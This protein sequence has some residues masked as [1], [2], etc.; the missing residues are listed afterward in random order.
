[1]RDFLLHK[2]IKDI[3]LLSYSSQ[4]YLLNKH[5]ETI[6]YTVEYLNNNESSVVEYKLKP[7][8]LKLLDNQDS[9][10]K[11]TCPHFGH[12]TIKLKEY[13]PKSDTGS[14]CGLFLSALVGAIVE[15][16]MLDLMQILFD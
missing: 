2:T 16:I 1:M 9:I 7:H 12:E 15:Y 5:D 10:N 13:T 8:E 4:F 6:P 14:V 11:I 3:Y